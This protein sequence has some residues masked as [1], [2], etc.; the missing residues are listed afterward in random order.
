MAHYRFY[1]TGILL[2]F[3][4]TTYSQKLIQPLNPKIKESSGLVVLKNGNFLT[5]NDGGNKSE[6]FVLNKKG[7]LIHTCEIEDEKNVDWEDLCLDNKGNVYIADIGN[8]DNK[9]ENLKILKVELE[10]VLSESKIKSK[11]F[12]FDYPNQKDFPPNKSE[13]YFDAESLVFYNDKLW[14][15]T[16]NRT[17]PFNGVSLCYSIDF[18]KEKI[19]Q[20][21][22]L[23]FPNT[24]WMEESITAAT[25][26][27]EELFVLTYSKIYVYTI[28]NEKLIWKRTVPLQF[29]NQ[30]EAIAV[31]QNGIYL[32]HE[33][34]PIS[35]ASLYTLKYEK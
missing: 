12:K 33:S 23:F 32:T 9:R 31:S 16:K 1:I 7:V 8:N 4:C 2:L 24:N 17:V 13:L 14:I 22:S 3:S 20:E 18:E 25:I 35:K 5:I 6:I 28:S 29:Y 21:T 34:N 10:K 30:W 15:F 27:E 26:F 11:K 19:K